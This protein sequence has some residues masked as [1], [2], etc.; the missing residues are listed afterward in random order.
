M[1]TGVL[2]VKF[3][4]GATSDIS[5]CIE[6]LVAKSTENEEQ[7]FPKD[8]TAIYSRLLTLRQLRAKKLPPTFEPAE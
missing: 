5:V 7:V 1:Q 6:L 8:I 4:A 3:V 2:L